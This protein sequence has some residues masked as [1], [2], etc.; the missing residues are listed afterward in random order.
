MA[1]CGQ[2]LGFY[3]DLSVKKNG[4]KYSVFPGVT[5]LAVTRL[6][7]ALLRLERWNCVGAES[8]AA[9]A[10]HPPMVRLHQPRTLV[11]THTH[12]PDIVQIAMYLYDVNIV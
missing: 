2:G 3:V 9:V 6:A 5:A 10:A 7:G 11:D 4:F 1:F 8:G 12:T